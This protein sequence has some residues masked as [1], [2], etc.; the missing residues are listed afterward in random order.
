[1]T[2]MRKEYKNR[3]P[4]VMKNAKL[5]LVEIIYRDRVEIYKLSQ[6]DN[7]DEKDED[8]VNDAYDEIEMAKGSGFKRVHDTTEADDWRFND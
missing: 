1:M 3:Y 8:K 6:K 5:G 4:V 7:Y 2:Q